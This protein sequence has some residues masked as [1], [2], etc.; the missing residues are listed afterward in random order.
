MEQCVDSKG[1]WNW[2]SHAYLFMGSQMC[3]CPMWYDGHVRGNARPPEC[4]WSDE[5]GVQRML[6]KMVSTHLVKR[7]KLFFQLLDRSTFASIERRT[8]QNNLRK[9]LWILKINI[10][11]ECIRFSILIFNTHWGMQLELMSICKICIFL[12]FA[13]IVNEVIDKGMAREMRQISRLGGDP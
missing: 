5:C 3:L 10:L 11:L 12:G 1:K 8:Y 9:H 4:S 2:T 7:I 13:L 6:Q